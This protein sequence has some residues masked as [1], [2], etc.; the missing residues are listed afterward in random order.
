MPHDITTQHR[1]AIRRALFASILAI[2]LSTGPAWAVS[3]NYFADGVD[4]DVTGMFD[5]TGALAACTEDNIFNYMFAVEGGPLD[6]LTINEGSSTGLDAFDGSLLGDLFIGD[7]TAFIFVDPFDG[8]LALE[9]GIHGMEAI[10]ATALTRAV[11]D[12]KTAP[13]P[14]PGTILLLSSGL[15][16][17]AVSR[18]HQ[19]RRERTQLG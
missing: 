4:F 1:T 9:V 17:L 13:V 16:G 8:I 2:M 6:G 14:E 18:W 12:P 3:Y 7:P 10:A 19:R 11:I 15:L 5:C